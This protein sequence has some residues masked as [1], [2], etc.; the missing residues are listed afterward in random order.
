MTK[1]NIIYRVVVLAIM[2]GVLFAAWKLAPGH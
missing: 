1:A 2:L